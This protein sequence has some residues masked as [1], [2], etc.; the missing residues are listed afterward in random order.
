M[1]PLHRA[2]MMAKNDVVLK[3][4]VEKGANKT[5]MT[6]FDE[7]AFDLASDNEYLKQQ[8]VKVDFLK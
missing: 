2:A 1:T 7:T 6:E 4:L 8:N 5:V 3:Y